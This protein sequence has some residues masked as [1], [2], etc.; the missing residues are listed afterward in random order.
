M[1]EPRFTDRQQLGCRIVIESRVTPATIDSLT[2]MGHVLQVHPD[3]TSQM[4]R[5]QA[6]LHDSKT[7]VNF[8]ASDP[9]ADGAAIPEQPNFSGTP[10]TH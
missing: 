1:E 5:G 10:A 4:G 6:V 7:G 3:Y 8:G 2:K 9:R